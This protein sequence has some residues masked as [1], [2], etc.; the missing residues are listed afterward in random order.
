MRPSIKL[1]LAAATLAATSPAFAEAP[2]ERE[3]IVRTGD[4]DLAT[5]QGAAELNSRIAK[6]AWQVCD[7]ADVLD[8]RPKAAIEQCASRVASM[9]NVTARKMV[10]AARGG[11]DGVRTASLD[12]D[13]ALSAR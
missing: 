2:I 13:I 9:H 5:D 1:V 10:L 7:K 8:V 3:V 4:L 12:K 6:A 11:E